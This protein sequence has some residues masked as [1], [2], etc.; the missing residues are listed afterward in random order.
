VTGAHELSRWDH[1][2]TQP[3]D[4]S[5][6]ALYW[7]CKQIDGVSGSGTR[8]SAADLA[9]QR[10]GQPAEEL[11]PYDGTRDEHS[12]QYAP[13][14]A[15]I[16]AANCHQASLRRIPVDHAA[17]LS[18]LAAG[19]A[20]VV[21]MQVWDAFRRAEAEPLPA[22]SASDLLPA[23]HAVV[24]AGYQPSSAAYLVRNSWGRGWGNSGYLWVSDAVLPFLRGAWAIDAIQ[25]LTA[26]ALDDSD[27]LLAEGA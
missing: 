19:R 21:A 3:D 18:E 7:G 11:W 4:L 10:W 13:P 5:E 22:P 25:P 24:I 26:S 16:Q 2:E 14:A 15:A 20:V 1:S 27:P 8:V 23:G 12:A 6:E 9:L 17:I